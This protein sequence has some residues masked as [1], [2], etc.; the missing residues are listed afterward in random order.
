MKS[1][2]K[3]LDYKKIHLEIFFLKKLL[4]SLIYC[5]R[6][7]HRMEIF[8]EMKEESQTTTHHT[9][10]L[11]NKKVRKS[12]GDRKKHKGRAISN[13]QKENS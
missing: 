7:K 1:S 2:S 9:D 5:S 12:C 13:T 6:G 11:Q 10:L 4:Q 3:T 8:T